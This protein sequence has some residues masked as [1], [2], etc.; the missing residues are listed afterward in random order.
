ME[1]VRF[2][3]VTID[4]LT[5]DEA[6]LAAGDLIKKGG[7]T[8]IVTPNVDHLVLLEQHKEL[9]DAYEQ[10]DLVFSDGMPIVWFSKLFGTPIKEKISGSDFFPKLCE[11]AAGKGYKMFFLGAAPGVAEA[12]AQKLVE[13]YRSL[14]IVE[15]YSPSLDFENKPE[16]MKYIDDRI[17]ATKPDILVVALGCPKQEILIAKNKSR[18]NVPLSIGVGASLDFVA[19]KVKRAPRW[20]SNHGLEWLYRMS[21]EPV[22]MFRRYVLRDWR[23][24]KL[25]WKYRKTK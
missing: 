13:S 8:F 3:N 2:L 17:A 20:M 25:L 15:C 9:R 16:E 6:V 24:L 4:N 7:P 12:A 19:G 22:R 11:Y 1:K 14:Q 10:A 18:W 21:Q 23:F 5:M